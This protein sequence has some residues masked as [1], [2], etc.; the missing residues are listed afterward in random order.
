MRMYKVIFKDNIAVSSIELDFSYK[1]GMET[2]RENGREHIRS[3][4][5]FASNKEESLHTAS[6]IINP[7]SLKKTA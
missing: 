3:M 6:N 5:V 2:E 4:V 1:T 7:P